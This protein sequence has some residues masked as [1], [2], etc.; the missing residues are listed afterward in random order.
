MDFVQQWRQQMR[1]WLQECARLAQEKPDGELELAL[2]AVGVLWPLREPVQQ[3]DLTIISGVNQQLGP[4]AKYVLR[5]VQAWTDSDLLKTARRLRRDLSQDSTLAAAI[6][7]LLA[8]FEA[9]AEFTHLANDASFKTVP[10]TMAASARVFISYARSDGE[11]LARRLRQRL[12]AEAIPVWQ[13]RVKMVGGRDWWLQITEALDQVDFMLLVATRGAIESDVV[14]KEWRYARQQGVCVI[15]IEVE[16]DLLQQRLPRWMRRAHFYRLEQEW[17]QLIDKLNGPCQTPRAPFMAAELSDEFVP[18]P[19]LQEQLL[20]RLVNQGEPVC[21]T[22]ALHG[23]GGYGKTVLARAVCHNDTI[24]QTFDDGILWI[25]LGENPG[26]LT[27]R[28]TDLIEVL[29]GERPG[30]STQEAA[31]ARLSEWLADRNFLIVLDDVWQAHHLSPFLQGGPDCARLVTTRDLS[32]LPPTAQSLQVGSMTRPEAVALLGKG[33]P[34]GPVKP[35]EELAH[36]LGRWP[37]LLRLVNG[38]LRDRVVNNN[39]PLT[40]ALTYVNKALDKRG[41]TAFDAHS[42]T[43]R[44]Q[45]VSHTLGLSQ[46]L[47]SPVEQVRYRE[48]VIFPADAAIPLNTLRRFWAAG[49]LDEA[50]TVALCQRFYRLSLLT[51]FDANSQ[52]IN[53]HNIVRHFLAAEHAAELPG[54]HQKFL[55]VFTRHLP[56]PGWAYLPHDETYLWDHLVYHLAGAHRFDELLA[57]VKDLNYLL[58]K[59]FL[60]SAN[61]AEADLLLARQSCAPDAELAKLH[62]A[63][64]QANH[65]LAAGGSLAELAGTVHS[66]LVHVTELRNLIAAAESHFPRPLLT[67]GYRLPDLPASSLVRTLTGHNVAVL[68]CDISDDGVTVVSIDRNAQVKVWDTGTGA[69]RYTLTGHQTMGNCCAISGDGSVIVSTCWSGELNI[70]DGASGAVRYSLQAH[71]APIYACAASAD[72]SV[73]VTASKDRTLKIWDSASGTLRFALSG[74]DR[75]VTGCA[76]SA[77]GRLVASCAMDGTI[78]LWDAGRGQLTTTLHAFH[79]RDYNPLANLTFIS[80]TSSLLSCALS[81]DGRCLVSA[82][83]NATLKVWDT[84]S[85]SLLAT[86]KGH[87]GWVESCAINADGSLVVSAGSDKTIKGW[88]AR[89]G[90]LLFDLKG[91]LRTVTG[92]A[93]SGDGVM[94]V[95]ASPDNTLKLWDTRL[96][97]EQPDSPVYTA[98]ALCCAVGDTLLAFAGARNGLHLLDAQ[99]RT[100]KAQLQGHSRPVT[101]C[102]VGRRIVVT[103]SQDRTLKIWDAVSSA[104]WRTLAGHAWAVNDC[105]LSADGTRLVSASDD[106]SMKVWDTAT[107]TELY[108]LY[109]HERGVNGCA[110]SPDSA[111][112]VSASADN[113]L[114]VWDLATGQERLTLVGHAGPV[115]CCTVSPDGRLIASASRDGTVRLWH[116]LTGAEVITLTGHTNFVNGCAFHPNGRHL[117][118]VS[119]DATVR[120]WQ[121]D[122]GHCVAALRVDGSLLSG[123]WYPDGR[124]ILAVGARGVYFLRATW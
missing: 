53:M 10:A 70:W 61:A 33:L 22:V 98:S 95:S 28:L 121:V 37:L 7:Q 45:A 20:S 85:G 92:C 40:A 84:A 113:T 27:G 124:Q 8:I 76:I 24:R 72:G 25:T 48:L 29:S 107:G 116:S 101:A 43:A 9:R 80:A 104:E 1:P 120:L 54:L 69:E 59:T 11:Q 64:S 42:A 82:L 55:G 5:L 4:H 60:R 57:T 3:F 66:R 96:T 44:N 100:K 106:N 67:A 16:P 56:K 18:R 49:G 119:K 39:Q 63:F 110:V 13:D 12:E 99:T 14:R 78:K 89:A 112:A 38:T 2:T 35:L 122:S 94:L 111:F 117:L 77:D 86:L 41:L 74:H 17:P 65:L 51:R 103:A 23:T 6:E 50:A 79:L 26:D 73:V 91:H 87:A 21:G 123:V 58:H 62:Q 75:S 46:D 31:E 81:A 15:P 71:D 19:L 68:G 32:V 109:G 114:K 34:A 93:V 90:D 108:T 30:F 52:T 83:P 102:A 97:L 36:R 118:S 47:L 115:T 88:D 105:A